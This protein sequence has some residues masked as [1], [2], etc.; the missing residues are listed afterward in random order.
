MR[1]VTVILMAL[2]MVLIA[3]P[4]MADSH[5]E[6]TIDVT[7]TVE[8]Y[9]A[10]S[11]AGSVA[12]NIDGPGAASGTADFDVLANFG[13]VIYVDTTGLAGD[14][15]FSAEVSGSADPGNTS[16]WTLGVGASAEGSESG[17]EY[18]LADTYV[19]TATVSVVEAN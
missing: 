5:A 6:E 2:A 17:L 15:Q 8:K 18:L 11:N 10:I 14:A 4:V 1:K 16:T 3:M 13:Y 19:G 7:I 12:I 9:A